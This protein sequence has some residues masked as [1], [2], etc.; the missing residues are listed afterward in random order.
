M[1][2]KQNNADEHHNNAHFHQDVLDK[3]PVGIFSAS[4]DG[5][6]LSTNNT[7]AAMLGYESTDELHGDISSR[8][9]GLFADPACKDTIEDFLT[10]QGKVENLE[11]PLKSRYDTKLWAAVNAHLI[12]DEK[13]IPRTIHGYVNDITSSK[14]I[15]SLLHEKHHAL[16]ERVKELQVI[17]QLSRAFEEKKPLEEIF[18]VAAKTIST[19]WQYPAVTCVRIVYDQLD[20]RTDNYQETLWQI[21]E[22]ITVRGQNKGRITVGYLNDMPKADQGPFLIEEIDLLRA[23]AV[24]LGLAIERKASMDELIAARD[25]VKQSEE[26]WRTVLSEVSDTVI[27]TDE[28]GNISFVCP[29]IHFIFG[30]NT[31]ETFA[32]ENISNL[33]PDIEYDSEEL[34]KCGYISNLHCTLTDKFGNQHDGL[35]G[36]KKVDIQGHKLM[37]TVHEATKLMDKNRQL[38]EANRLLEMFFSDTP[39]LM[40]IIDPDGRIIRINNAWSSILGYSPEDIKGSSIESIIHPDDISWTVA[41]RKRICNG[42]DISKIVNRFQA[43]SGE[44]RSIEWRS[45]LSGEVLYAV[46]R[47]VTEQKAQEYELFRQ[48]ELQRLLMQ[49]AIG[50]INLPFSEIDSAVARLL[51]GIGRFTGADRVCLFRYDF[52]KMTASA[53]HQWNNKNTDPLGCLVRDISTPPFDKWARQHEKGETVKVLPGGEDLKQCSETGCGTLLAIPMMYKGACMGFVCA[54][55][56]TRNI[57][58]SETDEFLLKISS[59]LLTNVNIR[60]EADQALQRERAQLL[61]VFDS[62]TEVIYVSDPETYEILYVNEFLKNQFSREL[63]GGICYHEFQGRTSPCEFCTNHI[64]KSNN[65]RAHQWEHYNTE[66]GR[67]FYVTDKLIKWP[68]GRDV[69][70]EMAV[71]ITRRKQAEESLSQVNKQLELSNAEK[72]KLFSII[73]HDLKSPMAGVL[74]SSEILASDAAAMSEDDISFISKEIHKSSKNVLAL[75]D[76][77]LQWSRM[78]QGLMDYNPEPGDLHDLTMASITTAKAVAGN[79]DVSIS[80]QVPPN[81]CILA[82]QPMLS[83]VIRNVIFNAVKFTRRGGSI[84]VTARDQGS[85]IEVCVEDDGV[86]MDETILSGVFTADKSKRQL[87]TEGEKGTGLGLILCKEFVEK[88]GGRIWMESEPGKGTKVYFTLIACDAVCMM[89]DGANKTDQQ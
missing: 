20:I 53:V 12:R 4:V 24:H 42:E 67:H 62:I 30:Y 17:Y 48:S 87:G 54:Q 86:G 79:K 10:A 72:D 60:L 36:V 81:L 57:V 70:F 76:D 52:E 65:G 23:V 7:L 40:L 61:S 3:A 16:G 69:R 88:H 32:M 33:L 58:W 83:T 73:G 56:L 64:I 66:L 80:C 38:A 75:L 44:Y 35:V 77:L 11:C 45:I 63:V 27:L 1:S 50:L 29:N 28:R 2:N 89:E 21:S 18:H 55:S 6:I 25:R 26:L 43:K 78:S 84:T 47:D 49:S 19:G 85:M 51:R 71:D 8:L 37:F 15:E 59:E 41:A 9:W 22:T 34:E 5:F 82:D 74:S 14:E 39:D 13:G 46:G 68:D 31:A